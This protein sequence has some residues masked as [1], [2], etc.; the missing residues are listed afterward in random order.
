MR[1]M[2]V[3]DEDQLIGVNRRSGAQ[4]L[5]LRWHLSLTH[6]RVMEILRP[7]D[8]FGKSS[9]SLVAVGTRPPRVRAKSPR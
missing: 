3:V 7:R 6:G 8:A 1:R 9:E 5:S 4:G 2:K